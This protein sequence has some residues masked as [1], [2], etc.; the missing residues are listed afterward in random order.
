MS[1]I[2]AMTKRLQECE[3]IIEK[4]KTGS[5]ERLKDKYEY[6]PPVSA[7]RAHA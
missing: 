2:I 5:F 3:D 4:L 7:A 6:T 1:Q